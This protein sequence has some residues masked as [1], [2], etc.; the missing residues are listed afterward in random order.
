M[1]SFVFPRRKFL[2][3]AS[4]LGFASIFPFGRRLQAAGNRLHSYSTGHAPVSPAAQDRSQLSKG[5][6]NFLPLG[7]IR[8]LG[9]LKS[10]LRI[11]ANGL[12]GHLDE[13]WAD[14]GPN[15]GW[16]G[17]NGESWERGPYF[18]D[19]LVPL[20]W[21]LD[22]DRLKAKAQRFID[23][24]IEHQAASGMIGPAS[25]DDWW[26]RIVMLKVLTQYEELAGDP[27]VIPLM[28]RYFQFQLKELPGRPLRDW[29]KFRW[30][31]EVLSVI[32]LYRRTGAPYL[33]D[34]ARLLREQGYDWRSQYA[35]FEYK[36]TDHCGV[37]QT[38]RRKWPEGSGARH[39][40]RE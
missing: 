8:P 27:R 28:D 2:E 10:H 38:E 37:S 17:G 29:G 24:T 6:F 36:V 12:S 39:A 7:S 22:D 40:W 20:A 35:N 13:T 11:Q 14:V 25:N 26:P 23:W 15:S 33:L 34:L 1:K 31:D 32:W 3:R 5:A 9:W 21:L 18:L 19:G 30:Q 4:L 16:L